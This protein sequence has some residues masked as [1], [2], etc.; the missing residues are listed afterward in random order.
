MTPLWMIQGQLDTAYDACTQADKA[1][2][3][4][5]K[6]VEEGSASSALEE[7]VI[8]I[9]LDLLFRQLEVSTAQRD[10]EEDRTAAFSLLG[11]ARNIMTKNKTQAGASSA[12]LSR[13]MPRKFG[14]LA[15]NLAI[16]ELK[17]SSQA[18]RLTRPR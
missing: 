17:G 7:E 8:V 5:Q 9:Q 6:I 11:R 1:V 12:K 14:I 2:Q 3:E 4:L 15:F 18:C 10:G 13:L 16:Q